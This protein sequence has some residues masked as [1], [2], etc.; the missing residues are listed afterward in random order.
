M[1][2]EERAVKGGFCFQV[3]FLH[4]TFDRKAVN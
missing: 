3:N 1:S 2:C 4:V